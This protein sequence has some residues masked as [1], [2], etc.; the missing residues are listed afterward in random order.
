MLE[1]AT[2]SVCQVFKWWKKDNRDQMQ[3][4]VNEQSWNLLSND[5]HLQLNKIIDVGNGDSYWKQQVLEHNQ[6]RIKL[7]FSSY[8]PVYKFKSK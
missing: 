5:R 3:V 8:P 7:H 4:N 2:L 1:S 6:S